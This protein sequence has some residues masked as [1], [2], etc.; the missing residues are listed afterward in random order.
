MGYYIRLLSP[1]NALPPPFERLERS[2]A[3]FDSVSLVFENGDDGG[4][5]KQL[6]LAHADDEPIA[7]VARHMVRPGELGEAEIDEFLESIAD[8]KPASAVAWLQA[9][10]PRVKRIYA[11][12]ILSGADIDDG[13]AAI[14]AIRDAIFQEL[15]GIMQAD[16]EGFSDEEGFH[17]LW[18]FPDTVKG[19]W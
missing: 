8:C 4:G 13:W 7:L 1:S 16:G 5:W 10:L 11:F 17:I 6:L 3:S 19:P 12:Q 18:Q 15:G 2:L 14:Y 9:Y